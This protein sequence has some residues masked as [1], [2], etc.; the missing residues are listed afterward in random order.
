MQLEMI[1][2]APPSVLRPGTVRR[3]PEGTEE[4]RIAPDRPGQ[5]AR[6]RRMKAKNTRFWR[7]QKQFS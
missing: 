2:K 7:I 5:A 3:A 1:E 6:G 4:A